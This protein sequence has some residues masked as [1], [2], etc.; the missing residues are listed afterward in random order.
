MSLNLLLQ[1]KSIYNSYRLIN[2]SKYLNDEISFISVI[3]KFINNFYR[4]N[5]CPKDLNTEISFI[6]F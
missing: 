4:L 2:F 1:F 3:R 6:L 5:N